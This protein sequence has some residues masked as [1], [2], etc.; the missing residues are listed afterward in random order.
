[1]KTILLIILITLGVSLRAQIPVTD[2]AN[3]TSNQF[4]HLAT[5]AKWVES[6]NNLRTQINQLNQQ[7]NIQDDL[8]KW[9]GNPVAAGSNLMLDALGEKDLVRSFGQTK[10]AILGTVNSLDSLKRTVSGNYRAI[11]DADLNGEEIKRDA[12]TFR[13]YSVLDATQENTEHV[14]KE[15]K[16]REQDLQ[17]EIA[18]TLAQLKT[19]STDAETQKLAAKLTA[20]NGQLAQ[21]D[22]AR[23]REVDAVTLQKIANDARLEEER[24]AAAELAA[25]DD[26]LANQRVTA[27]MKTIKVRQNESK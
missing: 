3:L 4:A 20:L 22:S 26:Y 25:K 24:L 17:E 10:D 1:M 13:R 16:V 23:R 19:A 27:Y 6:I 15:T 14:A 7:I 12:L 9:S 21:V 5:I 2:V 11:E 8:R 18:R